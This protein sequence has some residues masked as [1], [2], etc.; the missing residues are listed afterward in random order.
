MKNQR[1]EEEENLVMKVMKLMEKGNKNPKIANQLGMELQK[2]YNLL[3]A[4]AYKGKNNDNVIAELLKDAQEQR[5][6]IKNQKKQNIIEKLEKR[7]TDEELQET[8][9]LTK[10]QIKNQIKDKT[11]K[12]RMKAAYKNRKYFQKI[13]LYETILNLMRNGSSNPEIANHD[14]VNL[15]YSGLQ[16]II[17]EMGN[18]RSDY[19]NKNYKEELRI[20]QEMRKQILQDKRRDKEKTKRKIVK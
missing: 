7:S 11:N 13:E 14:Q 4:M 9:G 18:L 10:Q 1:F 17:R 20:A 12:K 16:A 3:V 8:F 19:N 2:F 15:R 6:S 5:K